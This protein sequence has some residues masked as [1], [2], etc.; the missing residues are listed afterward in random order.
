M[1]CGKETFSE[2]KWQYELGQ[3][4]KALV[5]PGGEKLPQCLTQP[6]KLQAIAKTF[7]NRVA[8]GPKLLADQAV[9]GLCL[10]ALNNLREIESAVSSFDEQLT[11][12]ILDKYPMDNF[13]QASINHLLNQYENLTP[14]EIEG[15][16]FAYPPFQKAIPY[17]PD[18]GYQVTLVFKDGDLNGFIVK[19]I[20][21]IIEKLKGN[22]VAVLTTGFRITTH[23]PYCD[24]QT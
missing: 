13:I 7:L 23:N 8:V 6:K 4:V 11:K 14:L 18:H 22:D 20:L 1:L 9:L 10:L 3:L 2:R 17:F 16:P 15:T 5:R 19:A 24:L 21:N 12:Q